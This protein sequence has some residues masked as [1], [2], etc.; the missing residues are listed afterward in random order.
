MIFLPVFWPQGRSAWPPSRQGRRA[1]EANSGRGTLGADVATGRAWLGQQ[2]QDTSSARAT[3]SSPSRWASLPVSRPPSTWSSTRP[4]CVPRAGSCCPGGGDPPRPP[5]S[6]TSSRGE[7]AASPGLASSLAAPPGLLGQYCDLEVTFLLGP[8][9]PLP[10]RCPPAP[11]CWGQ[12]PGP[13]LSRALTSASP[14]TGDVAV[15]LPD[16]SGPREEP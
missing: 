14:A 6:W 13:G 5:L 15:P 2:P 1:A 8:P 9:A 12:R 16:T 11:G 7:G 4:V 10:S 3:M